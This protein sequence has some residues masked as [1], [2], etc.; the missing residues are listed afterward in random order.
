MYFNLRPYWAYTMARDL[1]SW[2]KIPVRFRPLPR[3]HKVA[4]RS[5]LILNSKLSKYPIVGSKPY[6]CYIYWY[7]EPPWTMKIGQTV[8]MK[9]RMWA[10]HMLC[11]NPLRAVYDRP[12]KECLSC[13]KMHREVFIDVQGLALTDKMIF[14]TIREVAQA[15]TSDP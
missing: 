11:P 10:W 13:R 7:F 4:K 9:Q 2:R 5:D 14:R 3:R 12:L 6:I 8:N 15:F 1:D